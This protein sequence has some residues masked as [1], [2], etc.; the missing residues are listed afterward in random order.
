MKYFLL[1]IIPIFFTGCFDSPG[2]QQKIY[3]DSLEELEQE[4]YN[5]VNAHRRSTGLPEL[6]WNDH[7]ARE[8]RRHSREM[9]ARKRPLGHDHFEQRRSRIADFLPLNSAGEN[10]AFCQG[11]DDIARCVLE[12]WL[13]SPGHRRILE[14]DFVLTGIGAARNGNRVFYVTQIFWR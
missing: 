11:P 14:G 1:I 10:V 4:I 3:Q 8:A 5:Q 12:G 13:A 9:A 2:Q 6:K 7:I